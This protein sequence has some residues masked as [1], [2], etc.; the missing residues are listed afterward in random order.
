MLAK[1]RVRKWLAE[2]KL[3]ASP[4]FLQGLENLVESLLSECAKRA[5][6]EG[7]NTLLPK[8]LPLLDLEPQHSVTIRRGTPVPARDIIQRRSVEIRGGNLVV[9]RV[10][11]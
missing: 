10:I 9:R 7:R 6:R 1:T 2:R 4:E 8:D 5:E 11:T 3:K